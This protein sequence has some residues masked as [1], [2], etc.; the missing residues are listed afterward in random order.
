[1]SVRAHAF[2]LIHFIILF[3]FLCSHLFLCNCREITNYQ[4]FLISSSDNVTKFPTQDVKKQNKTKQKGKKENK[5][6]NKQTNKKKKTIQVVL[7]L[8]ITFLLRLKVVKV[9]IDFQIK[10]STFRLI[11]SYLFCSSPYFVFI[12][13]LLSYQPNSFFCIL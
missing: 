10:F 1:M 8:E 5:T 13:I 4:R 3:K 9:E 7:R 6:K 2:S 12:V 11:L